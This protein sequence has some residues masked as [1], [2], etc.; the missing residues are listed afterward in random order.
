ML[1][2]LLKT[3]QETLKNTCFLLAIRTHQSEKSQH[4]WLSQIR[5]L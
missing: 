5:F 2:I 1:A 4:G 3:H